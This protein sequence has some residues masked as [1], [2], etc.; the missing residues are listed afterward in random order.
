MCIILSLIHVRI[1]KYTQST[2]KSIGKANIHLQTY[3]GEV[4]MK[5]KKENKILYQSY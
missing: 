1:N 5:R 3:L 4:M 2:L